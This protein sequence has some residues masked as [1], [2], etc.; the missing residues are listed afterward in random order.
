MSSWSWALI[1]LLV[2]IVGVWLWRARPPWKA[3]TEKY[4]CDAC[5]ERDCICKLQSNASKESDRRKGG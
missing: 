4:I 2:L 1:S 5:S 3:E